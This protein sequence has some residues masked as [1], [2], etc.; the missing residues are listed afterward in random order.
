MPVNRITLVLVAMTLVHCTSSSKTDS[1]AG[2][3]DGGDIDTAVSAC[4]F[5]TGFVA[6]SDNP[7]ELG[8]GNPYPI[9]S[10]PFVI[11]D[12]NGF[13]MWFTSSD[14]DNSAPF[15]NGGPVSLGTSYTTSSDGLS[16]DQALLTPKIASR[17]MAQILTPGSWY[18]EGVETVT[19]AS[20]APGELFLY[21]TGDMAGGRY[22]IGLARSS[23]DGA[24]WTQATLQAPVMSR[25]LTRFRLPWSWSGGPAVLQSRATDE[26]GAV[27]P[28]RASVL[29]ARGPNFYYHY[30]AIV[31][32]RLAA[33]GSFAL[34]V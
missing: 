31:A 15:Y 6:Q 4:P 21:F 30:D 14:W 17:Q 22:A 13:R 8:S 16:W 33:D 25:C 1:H 3:D 2:D 28:T 5:P 27:Q 9:V 24:T 32:W 29:A 34:A 23:D 11:A 10:D 20:N 12:D 7:L 26:T 19:L 18:S